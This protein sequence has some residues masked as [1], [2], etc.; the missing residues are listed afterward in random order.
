MKRTYSKVRTGK[1]LS[2]N[3]PIQNDLKQGNALSPLL[4]KF[5]LGYAIRKF[6]KN[7]VRLK[8]NGTSVAGLC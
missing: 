4:F 7:Q 6:Q 1:Y 2:D 3:V 5:A 8:L